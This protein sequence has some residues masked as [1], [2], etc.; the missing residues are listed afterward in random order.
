MRLRSIVMAAAALAAV[1]APA[2]QAAPAPGSE[3]AVAGSYHRA[4]LANTRHVET[5][6]NEATGSYPIADF[7]FVATFGN[8]VLLEFGDYDAAAAGVSRATLRDHTIRSIGY[9]AARNRYV[10]P[11]RTC[12]RHIHL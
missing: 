9:A 8:A 10:H 3:D 12:G 11:A 7:L 1:A 2:A 6:W 5:T 4:L